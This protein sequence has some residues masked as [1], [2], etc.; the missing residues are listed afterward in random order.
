MPSR[1]YIA[2]RYSRREEFAEHAVKLRR[3][4]HT[5]TSRWLD[6]N[7]EITDGRSVRGADEDRARFANED[8]CDLTL[9]DVCISFTEPPDAK[10]SRGGRHVEF[11]IA[12][13]LNKKCIVI[14]DRENVFHYMPEVDFYPTWLHF[15]RDGLC[16]LRDDELKS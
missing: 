2:G 6:G 4:G 9:A 8:W 14:G 16:K 5:V 3:C 11:G 15:V 1:I 7:H 10:A 12:L 13:A